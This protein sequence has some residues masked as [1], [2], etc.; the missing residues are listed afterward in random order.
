MYSSQDL[1]SSPPVAG[2]LRSELV[3]LPSPI[4]LLGL[5]DKALEVPSSTCFPPFFLFVRFANRSLPGPTGGLEGFQETIETLKVEVA[6][7]RSALAAEKGKPPCHLSSSE[8]QG[9]S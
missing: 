5:L 1:P 4:E 6:A 3:G 9:G 2:T 7:L 8:P